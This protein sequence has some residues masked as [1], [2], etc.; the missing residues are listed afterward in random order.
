MSGACAWRGK[1]KGTRKGLTQLVL[2]EKKLESLGNA[3]KRDQATPFRGLAEFTEFFVV[4]RGK[5]VRMGAIR[6]LFGGVWGACAPRPLPESRSSRWEAPNQTRY[7]RRAPPEHRAAGAISRA[8]ACFCILAEI[9]P[10]LAR[11]KPTR[12]S[13]KRRARTK[14]YDTSPSTCSDA[15]KVAFEDGSFR[16]TMLRSRARAR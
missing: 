1:K 13:G 15:S 8:R 10:E 14:Q 12:G 5:G 9:C 11:Q 4:Q 2:C 7:V 16:R 3:S 6:G